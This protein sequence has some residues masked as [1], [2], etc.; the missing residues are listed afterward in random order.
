MRYIIQMMNHTKTLA[1]AVVMLASIAA[2]IGAV[3]ISIAVQSAAAQATSDPNGNRVDLEKSTTDFSFKQKLKNNCS[4]FTTC[5]NTA[6]EAL[7]TSP[8]AGG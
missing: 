7:A 1:I 2:L 3:G 4:G 8:V 5:S 6:S